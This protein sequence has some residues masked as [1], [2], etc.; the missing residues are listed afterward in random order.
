[1]RK[2]NGF[3]T[4]D[5]CINEAKKFNT[6]SEWQKKSTSSYAIAMRNKWISFCSDHMVV[7]KILWNYDLCFNE[8]LK[9]TTKSEFFKKNQNAYSYAF[10]NKILDDVTKHMVKIGSSHKRLI[11]AFEFPDKSVY[12]GLTFDP[13]QRKKDHLNPQKRKK[14]SVY[15]YFIKT[16][17]TPNFIILSDF[18]DK[19][20]A[21]IMEGKFLEK[22]KS[23][24]WN[25]VNRNK[26]G[27]LGGNKLKWTKENCIAEI[28]KYKT[29][30][31]FQIKANGAYRSSLRNNW[32]EDI[33]TNLK[34]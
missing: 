23:D 7:K 31:E 21:S 9:Y 6:K 29:K 19:E 18:F 10:R 30:T 5:R 25:I 34:K 2:E 14:S 12:V 33:K 15:Q 11:Y 22:Y 4:L 20:K 8:A 24:G 28:S 16:N 17:K 32:L 3:W 27:V 1:M 26:T 13:N